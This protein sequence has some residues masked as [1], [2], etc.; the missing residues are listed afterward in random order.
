MEYQVANTHFQFKT[1]DVTFSSS[2]MALLIA[3]SDFGPKSGLVLDVDDCMYVVDQHR[4]TFN[5][6]RKCELQLAELRAAKPG[7]LSPAYSVSRLESRGASHR[8]EASSAQLPRLSSMCH[9][10]GDQ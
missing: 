1:N 2:F 4:R 8:G 9:G 6:L 10:R 5:A 3:V 7:F